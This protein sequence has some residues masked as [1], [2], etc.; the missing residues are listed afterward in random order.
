MQIDMI[1]DND[2]QNVLQRNKRHYHPVVSFDPSREKVATLDLSKLNT[3]FTSAIFN[4]LTLFNSFIEQQHVNAQAKYLVGGYR[5]TCEMYRR[6]SLFDTLEEPR[7]LHLGIDI[8]GPAGT[9]IF[10]PLGGM[11]HSFAFN[12]N[13]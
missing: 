6:S 8:W 9:Q 13:Y 4:D 5:E 3:E 11:V 12:D 1:E 2:I 10:T 7:S